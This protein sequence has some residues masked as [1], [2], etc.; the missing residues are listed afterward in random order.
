[1]QTEAFAE[2]SSFSTGPA[3]TLGCQRIKGWEPPRARLQAQERSK[4]ASPRPNH[5]SSVASKRL[6]QQN[7]PVSAV[8]LTVRHEGYVRPDASAPV[9]YFSE[10]TS[11]AFARSPAMTPR[12]GPVPQPERES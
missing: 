4:V 7:R 3:V 10:T 11:L 2:L 8:T 12:P 9:M 6:L 5:D 1:M